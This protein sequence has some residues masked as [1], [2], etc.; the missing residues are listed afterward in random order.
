MELTRMSSLPTNGRWR[1]VLALSLA[2]GALALAGCGSREEAET[3]A[4][5]APTPSDL[6]AGQPEIHGAELKTVEITHPLNPQWVATGV[7]IYEM[8]CLPCHKLT[9]DRLVG[10][11]WAG[12]TKRRKP[13]WIL[14]MITNVDVM[15][16]KDEE[17]QK[18]LELCLVRMPNMNITPEEARSLL[19]Y[20]RH[21]D[22]EK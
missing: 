10:P 5:A 20:M 18:L 17:A 6:V 14:N 16:A 12:V 4:K 8:K 15:L 11:G 19:E 2:G 7:G 13:L 21:N 1:L 9:G 3:A 22:G